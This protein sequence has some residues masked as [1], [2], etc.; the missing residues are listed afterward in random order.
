ML[1]SLSRV[2]LSVTPGTAAHPATL[3]MRFARQ[4]YRSR[5]PFPL[6][7][8]LLNPGI[9]PTFP[10]LAGGFFHLWTTW[11]ALLTLYKRT[12][13]IQFSGLKIQYFSDHTTCLSTLR[14]IKT[15]ESK[16]AKKCKSYNLIPVIFMKLL[17]HNLLFKVANIS[18]ICIVQYVFSK[19]RKKQISKCDD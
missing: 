1:Q 18:I 14:L 5:L 11:K 10:A 3:S 6:P 9:K 15:K 13:E 12:N 4:E 2:P 17:Y 8:D 19:R 16:I 7:G